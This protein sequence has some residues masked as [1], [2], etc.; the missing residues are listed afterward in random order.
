MRT[1][2]TADTDGVEP[3][4]VVTPYA[5]QVR[6]VIDPGDLQW[7]GDDQEVVAYLELAGRRQRDKRD[8]R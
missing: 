3:P 2:S 5:L 6:Q 7:M 8:S 4:F 1:T